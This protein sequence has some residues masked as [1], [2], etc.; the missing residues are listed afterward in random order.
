M[1]T[2]IRPLCMRM[3]AFATESE[4]GLLLSPPNL[5]FPGTWGGSLH[6][7]PS[8][9]PTPSEL[10]TRLLARGLDFPPSVAPTLLVA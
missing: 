8:H 1:A 9:M 4:T 6:G 2:S 7:W 5:L 10:H 3:C